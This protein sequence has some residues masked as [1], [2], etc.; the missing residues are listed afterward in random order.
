MSIVTS[1]GVSGCPGSAAG[2]TSATLTSTTGATAA[3]AAAAV[4]A[5]STN[6]ATGTR[7]PSGPAAAAANEVSARSC[8]VDSQHIFSLSIQGNAQLG[9]D[10]LERSVAVLV[11]MAATGENL[12]TICH[13]LG[14]F[15]SELVNIQGITA[16]EEK[17]M[18]RH[19]EHSAVASAEGV[20]GVA[21]G[22][23][24]PAAAR[25][26]PHL[27]KHGQP[28][29]STPSSCS[30]LG[31]PLH[32]T[33]LNFLNRLPRGGRRVRRT[34]A[35]DSADSHRQ[36]SA[37]IA[38]HHQSH[39]HQGGHH[40]HHH[41]FRGSAAPTLGCGH[42]GAFRFAACSEAGG[43]LQGRAAATPQMEPTGACKRRRRR[44]AAAPQ[45]QRLAEQRNWAAS[46][47]SSAATAAG[48]GGAG[49]RRRRRGFGGFGDSSAA[50]S[51][52]DRA[53]VPDL[54]PG[55][56]SGVIHNGLTMLRVGGVE[57]PAARCTPALGLKSARGVQLQSDLGRARLL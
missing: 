37:M 36:F 46:A 16:D 44:Q 11:K 14:S 13:G 53:L 26:P 40:H 30:E 57:L 15:V 51:L 52:G 5:S 9:M 56:Y 22:A 42:N 18:D 45:S 28:S 4:V 31:T 8:Y 29:S 39:S 7:I 24:L 1:T 41:Q 48:G 25:A 6:S 47:A 21:P 2:A 3:A 54:E 17:V 50:G 38:K 20:R 34:D 10:D 35:S 55:W 49:G 12:P 43:G 32:F 19:A 27:L 33:A 23:G